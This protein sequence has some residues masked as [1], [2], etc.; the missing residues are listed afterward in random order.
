MEY[1]TKPK[2]NYI[3]IDGYFSLEGIKSVKD[4]VEKRF[5]NRLKTDFY[6]DFMNWS[7]AENEILLGTFRP[8]TSW[9]L[10]TD[11]GCIFNYRNPDEFVYQEFKL[12]HSLVNGWVPAENTS[13]GNNHLIAVK[14]ESQIPEIL[15]KLHEEKEYRPTAPV[16]CF[17]VGLC[18]KNDFPIILENIR[19][20]RLENKSKY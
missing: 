5:E 14:F 2:E 7:K 1:Q 13:I 19:K 3:V 17:Q 9:G 15:L 10:G 11:L 18:P 6:N 12:I 20:R 8:Y 4:V 16:G